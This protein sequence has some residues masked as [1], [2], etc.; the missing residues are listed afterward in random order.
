MTKSG[1]AKRFL[2]AI[3]LRALCV[4]LVA[5]TS[6]ATP[7]VIRAKF[8]GTIGALAGESHPRVRNINDIIAVI[9][10]CHQLIVKERTFLAH[11][12]ACLGLFS[13][14]NAWL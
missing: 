3:V 10:A 4:T 7:H 5:E 9:T 12:K 11:L 2:A 14:L 1:L 6:L 13:R 8:Q